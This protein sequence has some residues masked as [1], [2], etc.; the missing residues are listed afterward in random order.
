MHG[1]ADA[2]AARFIG[3]PPQFRKPLR[4]RFPEPA[5]DFCFV[6]TGFQ[7]VFRFSLTPGFSPVTCAA[8]VS[9]R[10]SGFSDSV[11]SR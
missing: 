5:E 2:C 9:S 1:I 8:G 3:A 7:N 4:I 10:F 11:Q 6:R